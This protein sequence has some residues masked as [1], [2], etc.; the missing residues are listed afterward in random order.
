MQKK[1]LVCNKF[2]GINR[3]SSVFGSSIITALDIQNVELFSTEANSGVGIRTALGNI[4]V[5]DLIPEGETVV[6][7][8]ESV[9]KSEVYFFVH[10]ESAEKG[11]IYLF[12]INEN[13]LTLKVDNL[14][15]T[16]QSCATDVSQGWSDLWVFSNGEE[17]L[18]IEIGGVDENDDPQEVVIFNPTDMDGRT[19][20]GLGIVIF[21]GRLW[22]FNGQTLWYSVQEDIYDFSTSDAEVVTSSGYIEF[23]KKITAIYPYLGALAV[24]HKNSSSMITEDNGTFS[25]SFDSPGGCAGYNSLVFHGTQL[26][27]YDDTKKGVFSFLQVIN[28]DKTLGENIAIDIQ[29]ELFAIRPNTANKIKTLSVVTSDR[30]EVWFLLPPTEQN[31]STILIYDY[32]RNCWVKRKS[33]NIT[34]FNIIDGVLYSAGQKIYEE[35]SSQLFDG[36]FIEA[37][38]KCTPLNL[39]IENSIKILAYPP[40]LTMNMFYNNDFYVEYTKDYNSLTTKIRRIMS[41]TFSNVLHYDKDNWDEAIYPFE[42]FNVIKNLPSAYFKTL[43]ISFYAKNEGQNFCINNI[44]FGKIKVKH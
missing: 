33:Q 39:G 19:V 20:K 9:Q 43:Q 34:C 29:E 25:K 44:E 36:E 13:T 6:N 38:Y 41:K 16:G 18:T 17:I 42:K 10:T 24:F 8:F 22:I 4:A 31:Y 40:K 21:A 5:C 32:L 3:S 35:Y 27:F 37:F 23:V 15:V 30:N 12:D 26:Y 14:S 1:S 11:R 28:G 7:I 2:S